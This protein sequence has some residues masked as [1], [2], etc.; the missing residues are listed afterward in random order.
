[1]RLYGCVAAI[2]GRGRGLGGA[3]ARRFSLVAPALRDEH[4]DAQDM[5]AMVR[6][7]SCFSGSWVL[8]RRRPGRSPQM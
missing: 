6:L 5:H 1:L 2:S 4:V 7:A 3:I 8:C